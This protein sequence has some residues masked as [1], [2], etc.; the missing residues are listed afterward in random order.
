MPAIGRFYEFSWTNWV[1][2]AS[3]SVYISRDNGEN[4][5]F[6]SSVGNDDTPDK[7]NYYFWPI[8]GPIAS[9]C[10]LKFSQGGE[11]VAF[12]LY[13]SVFEITDDPAISYFSQDTAA[14]DQ[15]CT[16]S[17]NLSALVST[18]QAHSADTYFDTTSKVGRVV[19]FYNQYEGRQVKKLSYESPSFAT[20]VSWSSY[21]RDGTWEKNKVIVYNH[22]GATHTLPRTALGASEDI[23]RV[24]SYQIVGSYVNTMVLNRG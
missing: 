10:Q 2:Y 13:S 18:I 14:I 5:T 21:A 6:V 11:Y 4:W 3:A 23:V 15:V 12:D 24:G 9:Q 1:S 16:A 7:V 8:T 22:E 20:N 17:I 19:V